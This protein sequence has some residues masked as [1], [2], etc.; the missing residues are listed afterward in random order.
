[1]IERTERPPFVSIDCRR[2]GP[3][4]IA[5]QQGLQSQVSDDR[6]ALACIP[7]ETV[8]DGEIVALD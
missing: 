8:I 2:K 6:Q 3:V 7:D 4:A 1:M 5:Q